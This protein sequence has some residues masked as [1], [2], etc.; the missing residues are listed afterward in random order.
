MNRAM[1]LPSPLLRLALLGLLAI[2]ATGARATTVTPTVTLTPS[3]GASNIGGI[4]QVTQGG[5]FLVDLVLNA[6]PNT[7]NDTTSQYTG[8]IVINYNPAILDYTGFTVLSPASLLTGPTVGGNSSNETVTLKF[9][10][11]RDDVIIG[12]FAFTALGSAQT[13]A[14]IGIA[15][16][17]S[18]FGSFISQAP[19]NQPLYPTFTGT[20]VTISAVPAPAGAWLLGTALG[21][22]GVRRRLH[23]A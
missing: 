13:V 2:A 22:L 21:W 7:A 17:D 18:F 12:R 15:D 9:Q 10:N 3:T 8:S 6:I 20:S 1:T 11:A 4:Y 19:T 23:R 5:N 14:T 16:A